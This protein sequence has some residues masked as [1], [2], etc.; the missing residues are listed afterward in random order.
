MMGKKK[1]EEERGDRAQQLGVQQVGHFLVLIAFA[2]YTGGE[3]GMSAVFSKVG[4]LDFQDKRLMYAFCLAC[5]LLTCW[6]MK[7]LTTS[8]SASF[9]G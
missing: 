9:C 2:R 5:L 8:R 4:F 6:G 3:D 1:K 7:R